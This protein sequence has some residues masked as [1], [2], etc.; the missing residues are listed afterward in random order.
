[1]AVL[2][3]TPSRGHV[4]GDPRKS[5]TPS[6]SFSMVD[7]QGR[8]ATRECCGRVERIRAGGRAEAF[9]LTGSATSFCGDGG[10]QG[11]DG[12]RRA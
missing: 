3:L 7:P 1:V 12:A 4:A 9:F 2:H 11:E 6:S 10:M 5:G 8:R